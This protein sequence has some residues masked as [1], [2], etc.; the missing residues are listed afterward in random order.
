MA[1]TITQPQYDKKP[2]DLSLEQLPPNYIG[3]DIEQITEKLKKAEYA[4]KDEFETTEEYNKKIG[5]AISAI[6]DNACYAFRE[7]SPNISYNA[8]TQELK[9]KLY[10]PLIEE[11]LSKDKKR[12]F[13][14]GKMELEEQREYLA[15][16]AFGATTTVSDWHVT[17][18]FISM[19]SETDARIDLK[20]FLFKMSPEEARVAK[21]TIEV[22][23]ICNPKK[24]DGNFT[25]GDTDYTRPTFDNPERTIRNKN[26]LNVELAEIWFYN[27]CSGR[28]IWKV[29]IKKPQIENA[30]EDIFRFRSIEKWIGEK[31]IFLK[32]KNIHK[33][34]AI[35]VLKVVRENMVD[36]PM[37]N[38]L[39]ELVQLLKLSKVTL[40]G[41]LHSK[42]MIIAKFILQRHTT[43]P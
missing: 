17:K 32:Q 35:R 28:I 23:L 3:Q 5:A 13:W 29:K 9:I 41:K 2:F 43:N 10:F 31:F 33:S 20:E 8:D 36:Q 40:F 24:I 26:Y 34:T 38:A 12:R 6:T 25:W 11:I 21:T 30:E 1:Q 39:E 42:W 27:R 18:W 7:D 16:N 14:M 37:K 22:L 19:L 4:K 15:T